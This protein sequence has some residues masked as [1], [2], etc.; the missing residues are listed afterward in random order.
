MTAHVDGSD[1]PRSISVMEFV[2]C[3]DFRPLGKGIPARR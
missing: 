1:A 2:V 3:Q